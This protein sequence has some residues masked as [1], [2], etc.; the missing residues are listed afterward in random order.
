MSQFIWR[1]DQFGQIFG[2]CGFQVALISTS[3]NVASLGQHGFTKSARF[4]ASRMSSGLT[5][6][7]E[8]MQ[9]A[10]NCRG[11]GLEETE[12]AR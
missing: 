12:G 1:L 3:V 2:R 8:K 11:A 6:L 4:F 9:G 5:S 10:P 7:G